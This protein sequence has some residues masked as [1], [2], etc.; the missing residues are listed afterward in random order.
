M[1]PCDHFIANDKDDKSLIGSHWVPSI[2]NSESLAEHSERTFSE[3]LQS[4]G[5]YFAII[6]GDAETF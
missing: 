4:L 2:S 6:C 5:L 1:A 3:R